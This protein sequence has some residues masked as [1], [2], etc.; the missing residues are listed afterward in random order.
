MKDALRKMKLGSSVAEFDESLERYF[1]ENEAFHAL[2]NDEVDI[3]AG[4][5]GTGKT[6]I[7]RILKDRYSTIDQLQDVEIIAAFNPAGDPVFKDLVHQNVLA[8]GQYQSVWKTYV[9]S[10]IGNWL[11]DIVGPDHSAQFKDLSDALEAVGLR[12]SDEKPAGIFRKM[13][14]VIKQFLNPSSAS[15]EFTL[16]ETGIPIVTPKVEFSEASPSSPE[17]QEI[18][19]EKA[20]SLIEKCLS[21]IDYKIWVVLDRLDEAFQGY[22]AVEIPALRALLRTYLDLLQYDRFKIKLFI[23]K[24]LFK[25]V[26]N[27]QFVN[28]THVNARRVDIVWDEAD[29]LN[30][31]CERI[32]DNAEL[33]E[34]LDAE[35]K[36]NEELFDLVFPDKVDQAERKPTTWNWIMARVRDG[37]GV[38]PPRNLID[39]VDMAKQDQLRAESRV[40][41]PFSVGDPLI[42]PDAIK[43]AQSRLSETR[44]NDTLL[45]EAGEI[46]AGHIRRF[47][48]SKSEHNEDTLSEVLDL[49]G[50]ELDEAVRQLVE[51]GF[52]EELRSTWKVPMLY[53]DGLEI[54]QGK[55]F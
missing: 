37:N 49:K 25:K 40:A 9:F 29:L 38:K 20:L 13:V 18:R 24:D 4:D 43:S 5:K 19:H 22:P 2:S 7:F 47:R 27:V 51:V 42:E 44:V 10:L 48:R 15:I 17:I 35:S 41:R 8:E 14:D 11:V 36:S 46:I 53:R 33:V 1:I 32:R 39:L 54:T 12:S 3:V 23:R 6:A 34:M 52:I 28:L 31:L 16:S 50:T 55:A 30:L 26:T 21:E 45:A